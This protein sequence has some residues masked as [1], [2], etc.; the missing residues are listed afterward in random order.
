MDSG[1]MHEILK[2]TYSHG[3]EYS[4][5][6]FEKTS[7][8]SLI[9]E[10]SKVDKIIKGQDT[11]VGIRLISKGQTSYGYSNDFDSKALF[12]LSD[13]VGKIAKDDGDNEISSMINKPAKVTF[14]IKKEPASIQ[15]TISYMRLADKTA[16]GV[17][18]KVKQVKLIYS[19]LIKH[20]KIVT[21]EGELAEETRIYT[22]VMVYV[23]AASGDIIQTAYNTA[24]GLIGYELF[25]EQPLELLAEEVARR[26][27]MMLD[28]RPAPSGKM[29]VILSCEAGGTMVHEA[30]G[31]GLEADLIQGKLSAFAGKTG[32]MVASPLVSVVDDGTLPNKR[33]SSSFDD[34]G[35]YSQRTVLI[36]KGKL[37]NFMYD[38]KT[39]R[40]D[41]VASTG[42]GRRESY[43]FKPIPRM[44]NTFILPGDQC[45]DDIVTSVNKGILAQKIGGGQVNTVNGD[46][47]FEVNECYMVENGKKGEP[48]RGATLIGNGP[49]VLKNITK[50]GSDFGY[51][52][53]TCGKDGQGVPVA[54]A[55]P[56]ILVED[57]T[58]GGT[59]T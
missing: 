58:V 24:G 47:V 32:E 21:S 34:E 52:I 51:A 26:A 3:G 20:V 45:Y 27:V 9:I 8:T 37:K 40:N 42:N 48:I 55:Q 17:S 4:D 53:G 22:M 2:R 10:D 54:D 33:G 1:F 18:S 29:K 19:D 49:E 14:S 35:T 30:V 38:K 15:K 12:L 31:H 50:V 41:G 28:A 6:Y 16:R 25:D 23:V 36:D 46:F 59:G 39:A 5:L 11:G 44:T 13:T 7:A 56:T 57:M 43:R